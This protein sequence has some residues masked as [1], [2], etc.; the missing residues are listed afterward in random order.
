[1]ASIL[2]VIGDI[3]KSPAVQY[4]N[5]ITAIPSG[6]SDV[7]EATT[8]TD[9]IDIV[10]DVG[11]KA[12]D[13]TK[14][15]TG[16]GSSEEAADIQ[17]DAYEKALQFQKSQWEDLLGMGATQR[18]IGDKALQKMYME[19]LTG[20]FDP[21]TEAYTAGPGFGGYGDFE[22]TES[23]GYQFIMDEAMKAVQ[24]GAGGTG[25]RFSGGAMKEMQDRAAQLASLDY[26]NQ[27][28]R[29]YD[30]G[31]RGRRDYE[32]DRGFGYGEWFDEQSRR[33][34]SVQ[35]KMSPLSMMAGFGPTATGQ[36]ASAMPGVTG[37]IAQTM[38]TMGDIGAAGRL[39][40]SQEWRNLFDLWNE[41]G[42]STMGKIITGAA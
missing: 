4:S 9:P 28:Q 14:D 23:P 38:G 6:I 13:I 11:S 40:R 36:M 41:M 31:T 39:G 34:A 10:K 5:P 16:I 19:T 42:T 24:Q 15:V 7:V 2:E 26:G 18:K 29:W 21:G 12:V 3:I 27:W 8:G 25:T 33:R 1:M 32:S 20:G 35:D 22:Y 37:N 30:E 17:S